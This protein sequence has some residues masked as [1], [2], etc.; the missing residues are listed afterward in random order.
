[1][2]H[3]VFFIFR[4]PGYVEGSYWRTSFVDAFFDDPLFCNGFSVV[5][6]FE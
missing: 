4:V 6:D 5:L 1:M 2:R 3:C